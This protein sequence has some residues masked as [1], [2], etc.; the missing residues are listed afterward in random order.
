[1]TAPVPSRPQVVLGV[2]GGIAAYKACELLRGLTESGHDVR[3]VPTEA[4]LHF[5]GAADLGGA[6]RPAGAHRGLAGR[7][8]VAARTDR[9]AGRPRRRGARHRRPARPRRPRPGR[10]PAHQRAADRALPG[11]DGAGDAHR[12]VG[13]PR[14]PGQRRDAAGARRRRARPGR[15]PADRRRQRQGP[16]ARPGGAAARLP[17]RCSPAAPSRRTWPGGAS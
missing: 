10:R 2:G 11:A 1:M 6:V 8:Q 3:V 4:A 5:V 12:D 13:A 7:R 14:H 15:G 9:P 17:A 16:A